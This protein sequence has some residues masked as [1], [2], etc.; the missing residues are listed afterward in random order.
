MTAISLVVTADDYGLTDATSRS[1]LDA[2]RHGVVTATSVL[3]V[4]PGVEPRL[5]WLLDEADLSVGVHLALVGEDPPLLGASEIPTLVDDR[6]RFRP[7]WRQLS[8]ALVAGRVDPDDI[9]RELEAQIALVSGAVGRPTHLDTHQHVH[10]WPSVGAVVIDLARRHGIGAVR[11]PDATRRGPRGRAVGALARRLRA[12][13]DVA[14]LAR[15][16]RFRG[17]DEAGCW[18]SAALCAA[19]ADL[20][21]R[22]SGSVEINLHPGADDDPDRGRYQWGY[23]WGDERAAAVAPELAAAIRQHGFELVGR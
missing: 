1:V 21:G 12:A 5:R 6:G 18:T 23:G 17:L 4:V 7:S 13:V 10:L 14:G 8:R 22:G 20:A 2:H 3:A 19:L 9:R 11:V 15:T 16:D